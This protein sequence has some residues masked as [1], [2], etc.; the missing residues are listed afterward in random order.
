MAFVVRPILL[1]PL[2]AAAACSAI[3]KGDHQVVTFDTEPPGA[4]CTLTRAGVV[5]ASF[6][7]PTALRL[8]RTRSEMALVC[9]KKDFT[10]AAAV[11]KS[12]VS[13]TT[14]GNILAGGVV[15]WAV[16]SASG[17]DNEYPETTRLTLTPA[18]KSDATETPR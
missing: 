5:V 13:A 3:A 10:D 17:A 6:R 7:T 16:D 1:A 2:L 12:G 18:P 8:E 15:G 11:L 14:F 9:R 4:E